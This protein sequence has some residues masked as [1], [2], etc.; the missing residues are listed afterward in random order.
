[1]S[2]IDPLS[3]ALSGLTATNRA[4]GVVAQ[5]I[6]N[7]NTPGY[8]REAA[9]QSA[10]GAGGLPVGVVAGITVRE[11]DVAVQNQL[12]GQNAATAQDATRSDAL[13]Q[14]D[15]VQ[16]TPGAGTDLTALLGKLRDGFS[17]L[18]TDPA[19][20]PQQQ[21]I[22]SAGDAFTDQLHAGAAEIGRQRQ[23]AQDQLVADIGTLNADLRQIGDLSHQIVQL[24][25]VGS[26]T[27]DLE[28]QRD[29]SAQDASRLLG[30]TFVPRTNG[31]VTVLTTGGLQL[32]TD[33]SASLKVSAA[34]LGPSSFYPG[35][36]AP[37][38]TLN[39][40]D[41]T[42]TLRSGS[43]G[44]ALALRDQTLPT[45][46]G[47]LDE[48]ALTVA[49]RFDRQGLTLFTDPTGAVPVPAAA[50]PRQAPYVGL[51]GTLI[52]NPA[53]RTTPA[54]VRDG[55]TAVVAAPGGASA[56]TPNPPGGPAGFNTMITRVLDYALTDQVA[57]NTPQPTP[58]LTSMGPNGS[59]ASTM[60]APASIGAFATAIVAGQAADA[61]DAARA[62][63]GSSD[64]QK[65]L[66]Q[67]LARGSGVSIDAE[68]ATMVKL[69]NTYAANARVITTMQALWTQLLQTVQ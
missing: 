44:G 21:A 1:M 24:R 5:N 20:A 63:T 13:A 40:Q 37:G 17:T 26:S 51:A 39:G 22:V 55:T 62:A 27:A 69:Q 42:A 46:Q 16:G 11:L 66:Q 28:N 45:Y 18:L 59:L 23:A 53:V 3:I 7:A 56:F 65:V 31:D 30:L 25:A 19:S 47:T 49:T 8:I 15:Q 32:A 41:V 36:G 57:A 6:A 33:G 64:A 12:T 29:G 43:I 34:T 58:N 10:L 67:T 14:L 50:G 61:A 35:G 2:R 68:L 4:L 9:S 38:V 52:V 60:A 54:L 48:F